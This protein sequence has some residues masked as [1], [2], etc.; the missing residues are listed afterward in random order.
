MKTKNML[1]IVAG[2][3]LA[4]AS[5]WLGSWWGH[6]CGGVLAWQAMPIFFTT[7]TGIVAGVAPIALGIIREIDGK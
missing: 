3:A 4:L 2:A 1:L 5:I 7:L 6:V